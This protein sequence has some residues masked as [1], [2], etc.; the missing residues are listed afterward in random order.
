VRGRPEVRPETSREVELR[1]GGQAYGVA[2]RRVAVD[3]YRVEESGRRVEVGV[4][5]LGSPLRERRLQTSEWRLACG[6]STWRV[7]SLVQGRSHLVEVEGVPHT[8]T[9]DSQG[10]VTAPAPA[11]VVSVTVRPGDEVEAGQPLLVLEAMKMETSVDAPFAGRVREVR[12]VPNVQVGPGDP[13]VVV[14]P[15]PL[16]AEPPRERGSTSTPSAPPRPAPPPGRAR[17]STSCAR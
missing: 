17:L 6:G 9:R 11:I 2:V 15:G 13:L 5:R 3:R 8:F 12:V 14:D 1:Q 10:V 16:R 7:L 4:E